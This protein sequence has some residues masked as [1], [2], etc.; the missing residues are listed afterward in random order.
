[1]FS[2]ESEASQLLADASDA[3]LPSLFSSFKIFLALNLQKTIIKMK[4]YP[5]YLSPAFMDFPQK[6]LMKV[7]NKT[8]G[9]TAVEIL[10]RYLTG[11]DLVKY[12]IAYMQYKEGQ[13]TIKLKTPVSFSEGVVI[14]IEGTERR[15]FDGKW[16]IDDFIDSTTFIVKSYD[17]DFKFADEDEKK[18]E[19]KGKLSL[20]SFGWKVLREEQDYIFFKNGN[21]NDSSVLCLQRI[22]MANIDNNNFFNKGEENTSPYISNFGAHLPGRNRSGWFM[23][24]LWNFEESMTTQE[25]LDK[26]TTPVTRTSEYFKMSTDSSFPSSIR[27]K[28]IFFD[29]QTPN[30]NG[31]WLLYGNERF[32]MFS[33]WGAITLE[34]CSAEVYG[35]GELET[36]YKDSSVFIYGY[37]SNSAYGFPYYYRF[38]GIPYTAAFVNP[39]FD[40]KSLF[41]FLVGSST[42]NLQNYNKKN[43]ISSPKVFPIA[44]QYLLG[45][46]C[47]YCRFPFSLSV[48][49]NKNAFFTNT[50]GI[51][52]KTINDTEFVFVRGFYGNLEKPDVCFETK[53]VFNYV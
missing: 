39:P 30:D 28:P 18:E 20:A 52:H 42:I 29:D 37:T 50:S 49:E 10:K 25:N 27:C 51:I 3:L 24:N 32:F 8:G 47:N 48:V 35:Y 12:D 40:R 1:M 13:V 19:N 23:I 4:T 41:P 14:Q 9:L 36:P 33:Y 7:S 2:T 5:Q 21:V 44:H 15:E 26:F 53:R 46:Y 11:K 43:V 22:D 38:Q 16:R 6:E 45:S 34:D 31:Y 17:L